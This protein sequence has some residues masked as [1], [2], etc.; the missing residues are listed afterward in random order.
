MKQLVNRIRISVS[1][2]VVSFSAKMKDLVPQR[3]FMEG[4]MRSRLVP[5]EY[6]EVIRLRGMERGV[7]RIRVGVERRVDTGLFYVQVRECCG[8]RPVQHIV[9]HGL[10][11]GQ[12][13]QRGPLCGMEGVVVQVSRGIEGPMRGR[14]LPG[15][16]GQ[17]GL[18]RRV[19]RLMF[20]ISLGVERGVLRRLG[21]SQCSQ[22]RGVS[23]MNRLVERIGFTVEGRVRLPLRVM[24][25]S[26]VTICRRVET[27]VHPVMRRMERRM[28]E[29][30]C[31]I[32][33]G[34]IGLLVDMEYIIM[35]SVEWL[36]EKR[37]LSTMEE[38]VTRALVSVKC[39][40]RRAQGRV[41]G[42]M[43]RILPCVKDIM[44][45]GEADRKGSS[46]RVKERI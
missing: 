23:G 36:V 34:V 13:G 17:R 25:I 32:K 30:T 9:L 29:V 46:A 10:R 4:P 37:F 15:E 27:I 14:L 31:V 2:C 21:A 20:W 35:G 8:M 41:S 5:G 28:G 33:T 18:L 12:G 42:R 6:S 40:I 16:R 3:R 26:M 19:E 24:P 44:K 45:A 38:R 39:D 11:S 22:G 7:H 43:E 1:P